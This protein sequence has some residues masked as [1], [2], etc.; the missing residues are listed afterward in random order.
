[1]ENFLCDLE[2]RK[3]WLCNQVGC[4]DFHEYSVMHGL[5][6]EVTTGMLWWKKTTLHRDVIKTLKHLNSV[7]DNG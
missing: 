3:A 7:P 5:V 4:K 6:Y 1:M 2:R